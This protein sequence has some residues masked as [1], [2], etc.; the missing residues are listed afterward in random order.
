MP[1][2]PFARAMAQVRPNGTSTSCPFQRESCAGLGMRRDHC[3]V[4]FRMGC[5]FGGTP[6]R[7][8]PACN[9]FVVISVAR[10]NHLTR[11]AL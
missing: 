4:S 6:S 7:L 3:T 10:D 1:I 2:R 5:C 8:I 9:L 11:S